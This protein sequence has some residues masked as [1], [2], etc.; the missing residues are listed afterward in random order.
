MSRRPVRDIPGEPEGS[1]DL[2]ETFRE[3]GLRCTRQ[4][5]VIYEALAATKAHPTAEELHEMVRRIEPGLSLATVYNT[6]EAFSETGLCRKLAGKGGNGASRYDADVTPHV[7]IALKDGRVVDVPAD[8][9]SAMLGAVPPRT[10]AELEERLGVK[11]TGVNVDL[12]GE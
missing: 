11:I 4:R 5:E 12:S 8:L 1:G 2:R 9:S 7:H 3:H 10:L 6:L